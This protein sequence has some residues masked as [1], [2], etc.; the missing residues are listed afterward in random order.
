MISHRSRSSAFSLAEVTV[1]LA[2]AAFALVAIFALLPVGLDVSR[3]ATEQTAADGILSAVIADLKATRPGA[4]R[5]DWF[6]IPFPDD[7]TQS[8]AS[9][10]LYFDERGGATP[11]RKSDSRY[12]LDVEFLPGDHGQAPVQALLS[13]TWPAAARGGNAQGTV[14][15]FCAIVRN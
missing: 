1:A 13:L 9:T 3:V 2:V 6:E 15:A 8:F 10:E 5:S 14:K 4:T 11:T 12:R 7:P